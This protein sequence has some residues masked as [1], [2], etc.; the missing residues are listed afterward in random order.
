MKRKRAETM[1]DKY[2]VLGYASTFIITEQDVSE[3]SVASEK[4]KPNQR[5]AKDGWYVQRRL[6]NRNIGR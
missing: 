2:S 5:I 1:V 4:K 3:V 6:T